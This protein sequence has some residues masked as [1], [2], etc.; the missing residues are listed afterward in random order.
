MAVEVI[1]KK[2]EYVRKNQTL[3]IGFKYVVYLHAQ[4]DD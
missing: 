2:I 3:Y 4:V 1:H